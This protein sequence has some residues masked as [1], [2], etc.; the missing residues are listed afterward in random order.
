[1]VPKRLKINAAEGADSDP[2]REKF[3]LRLLKNVSNAQQRSW[4]FLGVVLH[5]TRNS[6]TGLWCSQV[7]IALCTFIFNTEFFL[8]EV[9]WGLIISMATEMNNLLYIWTTHQP[10]EWICLSYIWGA[11]HQVDEVERSSE[12]YTTLGPSLVMV[13]LITWAQYVP[14]DY[15]S[16]YLV[17][18]HSGIASSVVSELSNIIY[19]PSDMV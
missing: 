10:A 19:V 14:K 7:L 16:V 18:L 11:F 15:H 9:H 1:M 6:L 13:V 17:G 4:T 12:G 8:R 2:W 5:S 3:A